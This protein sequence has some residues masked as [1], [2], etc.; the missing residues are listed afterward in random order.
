MYLFDQVADAVHVAVDR[1]P[2]EP[3]VVGVRGRIDVHGA[4]FVG[5]RVIGLSQYWNWREDG[6]NLF[7]GATI[8]YDK[9]APLFEPD[10]IRNYEAFEEQRAEVL[11]ANAAYEESVLESGQRNPDLGDMEIA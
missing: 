10:G 2:C 3:M 8:V 6:N 9:K 4:A 1:C 7:P 11:A 5:D